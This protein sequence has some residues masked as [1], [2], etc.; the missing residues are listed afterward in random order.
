[1]VL[2][3]LMSSDWDRSRQVIYQDVIAG[4]HMLPRCSNIFKKI[5][6]VFSSL[7]SIQK[8]A[9]DLELTIVQSYHTDSRQFV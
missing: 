2:F 5:I 6:A 1:M 4:N 9:T 7:K 3:Y 8:K